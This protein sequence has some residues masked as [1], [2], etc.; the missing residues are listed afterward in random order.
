[1]RFFFYGTLIDPDVR[2]LVLG[3][4]C[5]VEP[6]ELAGWERRAIVGESY[7]LVLPRAGGRVEGVLARGIDA[8]GRRRL[9][10]YEGDAYDVID[11]EVRR[12]DG[13]QKRALVFVPSRGSPL[14]ASTSD[15]SYARWARNDKARFLREIAADMAAPPRSAR[16]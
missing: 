7:P 2:T 3:A 11:V 1:M 14:R 9:E 13:R 5:A 15:W 10:V 4:P 6:A 16:E 8:P 12:A